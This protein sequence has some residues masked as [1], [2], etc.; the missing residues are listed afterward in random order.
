[1]TPSDLCFIGQFA[2]CVSLQ[3]NKRGHESLMNLQSHAATWKQRA[4][5]HSN[6]NRH[7]F[8]FLGIIIGWIWNRPGL[9]CHS[10]WNSFPGWYQFIWLCFFWMG[11]LE[12]EGAAIT[13]GL[14][15]FAMLTTPLMAV[16]QLTRL[17]SV[18]ARG[19][20]RSVQQPQ[21]KK[22]KP[23]FVMAALVTALLAKTHSWLWSLLARFAGKWTCFFI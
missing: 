7:Q 21:G 20:S 1:M 5:Y 11:T 10:L 14:S 2:G 23:L 15:S 19:D 18:S 9:L 6:N 13:G 8:H 12:K 22:Q 16:M 4:A 17:L 3:R